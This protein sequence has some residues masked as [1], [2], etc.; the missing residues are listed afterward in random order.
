MRSAGAA[1]TLQ[2]AC[3]PFN[4]R[5]PCL[6]TAAAWRAGGAAPLFLH[7]LCP[8]RLVLGFF[9]LGRHG[10][11]TEGRPHL[12]GGAGRA[13]G[14]EPLS[15]PPG[16]RAR[17]PGR[18]PAGG[19]TCGPLPIRNK[20]ILGHLWRL[21]ATRA[22]R[23]PRSGWTSR[24]GRVL[25]CAFDSHPL[26]TG[27]GRLSSTSHPQPHPHLHAA[28]IVAHCVNA[29]CRDHATNQGT[30]LQPLDH[31]SHISMRLNTRSRGELPL[32][33]FMR[34]L[35][36]AAITLSPS[37][38]YLAGHYNTGLARGIPCV[39]FH[40]TV[41]RT[42]CTG[43]C[44]LEAQARSRALISMIL[45]VTVSRVSAG[46]HGTSKFRRSVAAAGPHVGGPQV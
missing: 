37:I 7:A 8:R 9:R 15:F 5:P 27:R 2:P 1:A 28:G 30:C 34:M 21:G 11:R 38:A 16:P 10:P 41:A 17:L 22:R 23:G 14:P 32:N 3:I 29:N 43:C 31:V 12:S 13:P 4:A 46:T 18:G 45:A 33:R 44:I 42:G 35:P 20:A 39:H 40:C 36:A 26:A 24:S 19:S 25:L 6:R